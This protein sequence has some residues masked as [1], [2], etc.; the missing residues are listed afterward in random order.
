MRRFEINWWCDIVFQS[1]FPSRHAN[2]P[3][4]AGFQAGEAPFRVRCDQIVA[5]EHRKIEKFSRGLNTN[6]VQSHVLRTGAAVTVAVESGHR[7]AAAAFQFC[8]QDI[9][10]HEPI[11]I[12]ATKGSSVE[13]ESVYSCRLATRTSFSARASRRGRA[14][15]GKDFCLQ[16][17]SNPE[18]VR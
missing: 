18:A 12:K 9:R 14:A 16:F 13:A 1:I 4:V 3:L 2:A 17:S 6:R 7:I 8:S 15:Q 11:F 5:I 10:R